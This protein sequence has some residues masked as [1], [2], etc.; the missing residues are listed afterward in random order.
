MFDKRIQDIHIKK[1]REHEAGVTSLH[2]NKS[3]EHV[4]VS[5]SYDEYIR[6]WDI[7]NL[8]RSVSSVKMPGTLWRLKWDPFIQKY[9]LAACMYGGVHIVSAANDNIQIV[10]SYYEH[11]N[12][13]YGADWCTLQNDDVDKFNFDGNVIIGT[14]SFY[15]KLLCVSKAYCDFSV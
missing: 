4:I 12:I 8:K 10:K 1:N 6:L 3:R 11:K 14:C 9:L 7:R 13:S 15:E 5:G 2:S